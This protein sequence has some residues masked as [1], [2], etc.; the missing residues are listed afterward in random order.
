MKN[1]EGTDVGAVNNPVKYTTSIWGGY[2]INGYVG[3]YSTGT[4]PQQKLK[5]FRYPSETLL[6]CDAYV[7]YNFGAPTTWG[8]DSEYS[9]TAFR[10]Q[11]GVNI[12]YFDS[13]VEWHKKG[14]SSIVRWLP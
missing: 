12:N 11:N 2:S 13:H 4:W 10:H 14:P 7:N 8:W 9:Y 5:A 6:F 3:H 1:E